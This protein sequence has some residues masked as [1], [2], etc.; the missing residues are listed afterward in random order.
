MQPD[1][2]EMGREPLDNS[3]YV[4][5]AR[6]QEARVPAR[7]SPF[8]ISNLSIKHRLPLLIGSLLLGIII[9][10]TLAAYRGVR[11][12]ALEVGRERLLSL[13]QQ[14]SGQSQQGLSILL[15]K[16]ST[17]ANDTAVRQVLLSPSTVT[18][19][20]AIA[21]LQQ[22]TAAQDPN[23]L[24]VELWRADQ[25][26]ALIVPDGSSPESADLKTEFKQCASDP[27]KA[28]GPIRVVNGIV[29]Y[30][31]VAAVKDDAGKLIGCLLRWRRSSPTPNVRKQL[32]ELLGS[33]AALYY[34]NS[35]GDVWTDLE[36][37]VPKPPVSLGSTLDV[38]HYTRRDGNSVMALGRPIDGTPWAVVVEFPD[39]A[40]LTQSSRFLRR[41]LVIDLILLVTGLAGAVALSHNI[42]RPLHSLTL[43]ASGISSGDYSHTADTGRTDELGTLADAFNAMA[44]KVRDSQ[45]EL[46]QKVLALEESEHRL[47]T[48]IENLSE[49][50][51][52]SDLDGQLLHWNRAALEIHGFA[53]LDE[54]LL[55]LPM[56]TSIFELSDL[57]GCV[58][59]IE[60]WPLPRII[61]GEH[62]RN[63][64]VRIRRLGTDW[65]RIFNFG[66]AIVRETS[67]R[68]VAVVTMSDIT[69][70]KLAGEEIHRLNDELELRVIERTTQLEA[71]NKELEAFSY[72]ASHD[73][74]APLRHLAGFAELLRKNAWSHL[75]ESGRRYVTIIIE[76]AGRMGGL[77]DH[78]LNFSR[79]GRADLQ[80]RTV[81]LQQLITETVNGLPDANGDRNV[82]WR[83][84]ELPE[85]SGDPE[86]LSLV[87]TN[88]ISNALKFSRGREHPEI[89]IGCSFKEDEVVVFIRDNG[90][91]FDMKYADKLFGVFQRLHR[92]D[93]FE[94]T[95]IGLA[96]V[97]RIIARHGGQTWAQGSNGEGATFYFSL[98]FTEERIQV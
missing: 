51:V 22:F 31:V 26:V 71:A 56:F 6:S 50:L 36:K 85:V 7:A 89:E 75:D 2:Y 47:Q 66:G 54:C 95:G 3:P 64:E 81:N 20:G 59:G 13:T 39:R 24:Q 48:V 65:H 4:I 93:E 73:L 92:D 38:T 74:R 63:L 18:R 23:S 29:V 19:S 27:F 11:D 82:T 83:I 86:L 15:N 10:S 80:K 72:S 28:V 90:A 25:S 98:P 84:G 94:G 55:K 53:S 76:E 58:L 60:Q 33:Q 52:V 41:M 16:T 78:L 40:F 35:Q 91:G 44:V 8:S 87:L 43:A 37:S 70:R 68:F 32:A 30:T 69:E 97:R 46:E 1:N 79:L 45:I 62:L 14:L 96:N 42:T 21:L 5:S 61:R 9:F 49:G 57:D 17:T 77:I 88:L 67:G 34:G 12:S